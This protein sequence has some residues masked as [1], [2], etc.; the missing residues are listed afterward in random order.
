MILQGFRRLAKAGV[1]GMNMRNAGYIMACNARSAFPLVDDKVQTKRLA[2][3]FGIPSPKVYRV[4]ENHGSIAGLP[5]LLKDLGEFVLKPARG[6]GGSGI[7]LVRGRQEEGYVT[8]SGQVISGDDFA[9]HISSILSGIFSLE[10][11]EDAAIIESLIHPDPVF[12]EVTYQEGVPDIRVII[13]RGVPVMAMV[14]LPTKASDGKANLHRGAIGAGIDLASGLTM[15]AVH[16][17]RIV[18][19]HPDTDTPVG[20]IPIPHWER[21]LLMA[22]EATRM[23]GLGYLGADFVLDR[24]TGPVL[25]ELNARPGLAIQIANQAGLRT[26]LDRTDGAPPAVFSSAA[27]RVTWARENLGLAAGKEASA[28]ATLPAP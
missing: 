6:S 2:E 7:I 1:L 14:R 3:Q 24:D 16:N 5:G 26:R 4:I 19:R 18:T 10:G 22:A 15:T 11:M 28:P 8:Q 20:G 27:S 25:L 17:S 13:Y 9:Y 23:T 12:A 21:I